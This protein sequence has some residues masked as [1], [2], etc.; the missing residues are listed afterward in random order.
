MSLQKKLVILLLSLGFVFAA[1]SYAGLSVLVFPAF[2]TFEQESAEQTVTRVASALNAELHSLQVINREYSE[3]DHTY[4]YAQ[5]KRD[6]YVEENLDVAYWVNIDIDMMAVYD[7]HGD[8]LWGEIAD[9][10]T[11]NGLR[12]EGEITGT[13]DGD[14]PLLVKAARNGRSTGILQARY[15]PMLVSAQPIV[16]TL[17]TGPSVGTLLVGKYLDDAHLQALAGRAGADVGFVTVNESLQDSESSAAFERALLADERTDWVFMGGRTVAY[18]AMPDAAGDPAFLLRVSTPRKITAIGRNAINLTLAFYIAATA[19]FLLGAWFFMK[20]SIVVPLATLTRDVVRMRKTGELNQVTNTRRNDEIGMLAHEFGDL[21]SNLGD[22]QRNLESAQALE[23]SNAKTDFLARMSHEIRT[24]MNGVLGMVELLD[25]TPLTRAQKR[26]AHSIHDSAESLLDIIDD[27]LDFSKIEAG[28]LRLEKVPFRLN[29]LLLDVTDSLSG[30]AHEK[31]LRI[32]CVVPDDDL[33]V[34]SDPG[35][36]RQVLT[37]LLGNAIKFTEQGSVVLQA[38]A[39]CRDDDRV[40]VTFEVVD[41]G[42]GIAPHRQRQIFESF[43]QEDGSTTRRFGGT[44]LGLSISRE[45]VEMMGSRL[46]L[47]SRPGTGSSF[48]FTLTT[49]RADEAEVVDSGFTFRGQLE[50]LR[51]GGVIKR[52]EGRVLIVEDNAV[53]Q[54]VA[55]GMA[56]AMGLD[57]VVVSDG[58]AAVERCGLEAFDAILMD[59]QMPGLDGYEATRAIR[60]VEVRSGSRSVPIIAV[61]ANAL[62]GDMEKCVSAGMDDYV[63]KPFNI[64]QLYASLARFLSTSGDEERRTAPRRRVSDLTGVLTRRSRPVIDQGVLESLAHLPQTGE[65]QLA[66]RVVKMYLK[67]TPALMAKLGDALDNSDAKCIRET[68][69]ALKSSSASVGAMGLADLF[70]HLETAT[71]ET[72]RGRAKG[73]QDQIRHEYELVLDALKRRGKDEAA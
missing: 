28:K 63:S 14:H 71:R 17:A 53:N 46:H 70:N 72:D 66:G 50:D 43:A 69:H 62:P 51:E 21:T 19:A 5:G 32:N 29:T 48:Y 49:D 4:E 18:R 37:N 22:A 54:A 2:E 38:S 30:L 34:E 52:L 8:L 23:V 61:T 26:Y 9:P 56:E 58:N 3:W 24:P 64:N 6:E 73:L 36:I 65:Q 47:K 45:L 57:T 16:T 40:D 15:A 41:T 13:L 55:A 20:H 27:I 67:T 59:I 68:A 39:K 42:I 10:A 60:D 25:R 33:A 11:D 35:R 1:G 31:G 44:G 12:I 7:L